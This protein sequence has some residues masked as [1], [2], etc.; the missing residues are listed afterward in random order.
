MKAFVFS[1]Q[2]AFEPVVK[3]LIVTKYQNGANI[4][5][6]IVEETGI[7]ASVGSVILSKVD[8]E[9]LIRFFND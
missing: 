4:Q 2:G 6:T 1:Q 9:E 7:Q 5:F 3:K 8:L